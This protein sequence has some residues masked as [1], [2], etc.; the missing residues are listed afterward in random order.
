[1]NLARITKA[2]WGYKYL[3]DTRQVCQKKF[4]GVDGGKIDT[5]NCAQTVGG[6]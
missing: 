3:S 6:N 4:A 1:M 5:I 2:S